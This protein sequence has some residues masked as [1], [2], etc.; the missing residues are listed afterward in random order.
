MSVKFG[1][2][3]PQGWRMDLV[4]I[5][6]PLAQYE[7]MTAVGRD[8]EKA[9]FD[10]IWVYD[11]FHTVP[12][13]EME[14][15]FECWSITAGLARDTSSIKIG[16]MV[17]CNG[18]RNPALLAK[19]ASTI[20]VM[21]AGR[22]LC[23][24]GAGWYEHEWRAYGYGFPDVPERMRAFREA[25]EIVVKMWTEEKPVYNG[26]FYTID[27]PINEPKGIQKPHIP[28]WLGG[29]GEKVTLKLVAKYGQACNVGGGNPDTIRQ[30]LAVLKAHC[31]TLGRDYASIAKSTNL[32]VFMINPG[33]D[34]EQATAKAR[35]KASLEEFRK[36]TFVGTPEQVRE[37][38]GQVVDAGADYVIVYLPRVAYERE[39]V[40]QFADE[41]VKHF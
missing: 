12:T 20:D 29:G 10:S 23:G 13:P 6:D 7:A 11:H 34:P 9:G 19:I 33:E 31:D 2:F 32:N 8:A 36:A 1:V 27:G 25:V 40:A 3:V 38:V 39:R 14:T 5:R 37:R 17:T 4:E 26:K 22:L 16:Q 21:S 41:V 30:K 35:G 28:L 24:L 18:Y 15:T